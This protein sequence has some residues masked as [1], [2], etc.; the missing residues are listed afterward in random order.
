M[1]K[2]SRIPWA[3][4]AVFDNR[5]PPAGEIV[6]IGDGEADVKSRGGF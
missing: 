6:V 3:C 1:R 5:L 4:H 2:T